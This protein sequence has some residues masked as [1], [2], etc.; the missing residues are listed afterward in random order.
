[1]TFGYG[2]GHVFRWSAGR[3]SIL[4]NEIK[5]FIPYELANNASNDWINI[6]GFP[7]RILKTIQNDALLD[8]YRTQFL[9]SRAQFFLMLKPG[10]I[11]YASS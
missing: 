6:S 3:K 10:D 5:I 11:F 2:E 9:Y 1:M 4:K 8:A 7:N